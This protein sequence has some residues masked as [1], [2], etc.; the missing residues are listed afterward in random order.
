MIQMHC[1]RVEKG[2]L[3]RTL[4]VQRELLSD[5]EAYVSILLVFPMH[6]LPVWL[7]ATRL[8]SQ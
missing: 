5:S 1:H 7:R 3:Y 8:L 4:F 2:G 6:V